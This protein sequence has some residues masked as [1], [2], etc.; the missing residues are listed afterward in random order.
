MWISCWYY[1]VLQS[2]YH[3]VICIYFRPV[4]PIVSGLLNYL[5][6][7]MPTLHEFLYHFLLPL[8]QNQKLQ[9]WDRH[10]LPDVNIKVNIW[11]SCS[12]TEGSWS[13]SSKKLAAWHE[14]EVGGQHQHHTP[15]HFTPGK[16][17]VLIVQEAGWASEPVW[18]W[19]KLSPQLGFDLQ[20]VQPVVS[21]CTDWAVPTT[22]AEC[23]C[24]ILYRL[25]SWLNSLSNATY[26]VQP[27]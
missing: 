25:I 20:T 7:V 16:D 1:Q 5:V 23:A 3:E 27:S 19:Q 22:V 21:H 18:P 26:S 12:G 15:R 8:L 13:Y 4:P 11:H 2:N 9:L 14:K 24:H 10:C 17:S 6:L